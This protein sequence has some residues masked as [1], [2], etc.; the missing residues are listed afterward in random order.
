MPES[1]KKIWRCLGEKDSIE[2]VRI[3]TLAF[4]EFKEG[5]KTSMP[6]PLFPRM[7]L[8]DFLKEEKKQPSLIKKEE[9]MDIVSFDEF[10]RMDLRVAEILKA[11]KIEGADK[12]L[13]LQV[14][15]GTETRQLV[16]GIA[17][18]YDPQEL[19]GKKVAVIVNLKPAVIR[20][21]ESRGMI[22]AAVENDKAVLSFYPDNLPSGAKIR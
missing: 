18:E 16:A 1:S 19:E 20:G 22:L 7:N 14:D 3:K 4:E 21:V 10:K 9:T 5:Q 13:K 15:I 12:L 2:R 17:Q 8:K 11:E 6:E